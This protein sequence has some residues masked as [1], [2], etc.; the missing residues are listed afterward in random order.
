MRAL[1]LSTPHS[2]LNLVEIPLPTPHS[3]SVLLRVRACGVC[4]TDLH[5]VEGDLP[6]R[7]L[8]ITPG[9]QVVAIVE[10]VGSGATVP[11][12]SP[13]TALTLRV[14]LKAGFQVGD[15]VGVPWLHT[16]CGGCEFCK[17]GE[18]NLCDHARFT[19]WDVDGGYADYM[20]ADA[21]AL[22]PIPES[23]SDVEAAPLLC[24][25]IV[26]YRSLV[27]SDLQPGERLGIFGFGASGHIALQ[28]ARYRDCP[29]SVFTRSEAHRTLAR[30]LGAEWAGPAEASPPRPLDR[31]I[32][33][34]PAGWLVP[35]ALGHL[36][37]GGTLAINA[38]HTS[39]IPEMKY[40]LLYWEKT[41]RSVANATHRDAVEFMQ[42]AAQVPIKT[43]VTTFPLE[44]ANEVLAKLKRGEINGAA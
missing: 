36:R 27:K 32:I 12:T 38:I 17:R 16:T 26:G 28:V 4:H 42:L 14:Q 8:P 10:Q 34:A 15:R 9:H 3:N 30:S 2:P 13:S 23:F 44:A 43:E 19:G 11:S 20:L 6:P 31:A 29:V 33:F 39:P 37:K 18:E 40:D 7:K 21:S 5:I 22:A 41:I 35:L 25:G 1:Q 24:A